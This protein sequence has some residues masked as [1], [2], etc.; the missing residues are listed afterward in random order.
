MNAA[1]LDMKRTGKKSS[2]VHCG[3]LWREKLVISQHSLVQ[4]HPLTHPKKSWGDYK[5]N[6]YYIK[7]KVNAK[8]ADHFAVI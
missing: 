4:Y 6:N 2:C 7:E 8:A 1:L 3:D 5:G